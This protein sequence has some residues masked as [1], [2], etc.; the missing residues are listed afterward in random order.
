MDT[1]GPDS[2][3]PASTLLRT[4]RSHREGVLLISGTATRVRFVLDGATGAVVM[5]LPA[6]LLLAPGPEA[7]DPV[8]M[9]AEESEGSLQLLVRLSELGPE[10]ED[11]FDRW[12]AYHGSPRFTR[13]ASLAIE[14][15]KM[16]GEVADGAEL[17]RPNPLLAV[18]PALCKRLNADRAALAAACRKRAG[19][20]PAEPVA[21]GVDP[22]G[23]DVRARFGIVRVE[24]ESEA[25]TPEAAAAA[26]GS[27]LQEGSA[28]A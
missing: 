4:L 26:V 13:W 25:R 1:T 14:S 16:G 12:R 9:V 6:T 22:G 10:R 3:E 21:V 7:E 28:G 23:V 2:T 17:M 27:L 5:P 24:F 11:V 20:A 19:L 18:E 15:G 8:L